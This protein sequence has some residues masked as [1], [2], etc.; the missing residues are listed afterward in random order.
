MKLH[1]VE[2]VRAFNTKAE[3][4]IRA[5][6]EYEQPDDA[7]IVKEAGRT[8][9]TSDA[10]L[11]ARID[12]TT[13][14]TVGLPCFA[15][16]IEACGARREWI[17][18]VVFTRLLGRRYSTVLGDGSPCIAKENRGRQLALPVHAARFFLLTTG[19]S[20]EPTTREAQSHGFVSAGEDFDDI[21]A[22][23][24]TTWRYA[25]SPRIWQRCRQKACFV[26]ITGQPA[27]VDR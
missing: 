27:S 16:S 21:R 14:F 3:A 12:G 22:L 13:N 20:S 9:G 26:L 4:A 23:G 1:P 5:V 19:L 15:T 24:S 10:R 17:A 11:I 6:L 7:I 8:E 2:I 18:G 25:P